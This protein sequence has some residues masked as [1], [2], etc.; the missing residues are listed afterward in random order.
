MGGLQQTML[1]ERRGASRI[2][3]DHAQGRARL[4]RVVRPRMEG[5]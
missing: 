4:C 1:A 2:G 5:R 3:S